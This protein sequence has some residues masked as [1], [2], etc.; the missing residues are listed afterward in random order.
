[1][2]NKIAHQKISKEILMNYS[3]VGDLF[4]QK[5]NDTPNKIFLNIHGEEKEQFTYLELKNLVHKA[6]IF[7]QENNIKKND[8]ISLIFHNS[9]EFL[10]LYFAALCSGVTVVPINPDM[11]S[12]EI[13]FIVRNS[14]SKAIFYTNTIKT[15]IN[16]VS[17]KFPE[18]YFFELKSYEDL[19]F[20]TNNDARLEL[21]KVEMNDIA[22]IIYTSGTT[23]NPK[24]VILSHMNL[25]FD[26]MSISEWFEFNDET[27]CLCILPLFHNN[28]Q[29]TTLLAPLFSGGS[30]VIVRGKV[31]LYAFWYLVNEYNVTWTSVMS[32]IL[33]ILLSFTEERKDNSL[34]GIL[35]GGQVLTRSIQEKFERRFDVPIFEGYGLTETTSFSC[36]NGYPKDKR[37]IGSIGKPLITNEMIILNHDGSPM[38][39]N[40]EGEICIRGYNVAVGYLGDQKINRAF[41]NGWFHSGD[42]GRRDENGNYYFHGRHDSLIIK[43]G[44][45]IYPAEIESVLYKHEAVD[46]CAVIGIPDNMLGEEICAFVKIKKAKKIS[47]KELK[48]FCRNKIADFKQPKEI[49]IINDLTD[50]NEIPKGPTKKILYRKLQEYYQKIKTQ[51][52][53]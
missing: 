36:I 39:D 23:G 8:R 7:L 53:S 2:S 45:N 17:I 1:M 9:S 19:I 47:S 52:A 14:N 48:A 10:I 49:I 40:V 27:K 31:S 15:K 32:S 12:N 44:E 33:A 18:N 3:N 24:G 5:V 22:V 34:T 38:D 25:L 41:R 43:G 26:A 21:E 35:C 16:P 4:Y 37:K 29:I 6:M 51:N 13:E 28:G 11:T 42:F 46:E 20:M 50:L 30:T